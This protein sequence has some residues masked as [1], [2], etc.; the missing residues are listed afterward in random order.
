M[1]KRI[2]QMQ[3]VADI[4]FA[5]DKQG[6]K[7]MLTRQM[8]AVVAAA[9]SIVAEFEKPYQPARQGS[10]LAE[11]LASDDTG[12]SSRFMAFA[13][14]LGPAAESAYPRDSD[15]F[16]RCYKMLRSAPEGRPPADMR[17]HGPVWAG[18][19]AAWPE[20]ERLYEAGRKKW[21]ELTKRIGEIVKEAE[22]KP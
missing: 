14:R 1:T 2:N 16:G 10:G 6:V 3:L 8:N 21:P 4:M 9:D 19:A 18:L 11:W 17:I 13:L 7:G 5:L 20:L 12:L 22:G 15:D